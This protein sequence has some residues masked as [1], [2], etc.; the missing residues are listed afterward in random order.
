MKRTER[1]RAPRHVRVMPA[2]IVFDGGGTRAT[3]LDVGLH[4]TRVLADRPIMPGFH[5]RLQL[6]LPEDG[7]VEM[8]AIVV[9]VSSPVARDD[10]RAEIAL[11][12]TTMATE[13]RALWHTFIGQC[14]AEDAVEAAMEERARQQAEQPFSVEIRTDTLD[15]ILGIY[16]RQISNGGLVLDGVMDRPVGSVVHITFV[17]PCAN[18]RFTLRGH[19]QRVTDVAGRK[20][21]IV[22][23]DGLAPG[24]KLEFLHFLGGEKPTV[25]AP[26]P[27][28]SWVN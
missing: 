23:F 22:R 12:F 13:H 28:T 16:E 3:T 24:W 7:A 1:R 25:E 8:D 11:H 17:H 21:T 18:V 10:G 14:L 9:R 27:A 20:A 26:E 6:T 19:V 4:G 2:M 5:V 15:I